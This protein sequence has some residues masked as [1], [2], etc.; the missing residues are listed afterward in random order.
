M[1]A[2]WQQEAPRQGTLWQR[3]VPIVSAAAAGVTVVATFAGC[4]TGKP[5]AGPAPGATLGSQATT[6]NTT[7]AT[8]GIAGSAAARVAAVQRKAQHAAEGEAGVLPVAPEAGRLSQ[9]QAFPSTHDA[10]FRDAMDDLWLAVTRDRPDDASRAFFPQA[11]YVQT[12]A[13]SYAGSD[14]LNRLWLDFELDVHAAHDLVGGDAHLVRVDMA[15]DGEAAWVPPGY[16]Y[17]AVGYWHINGARLVY[18]RYG[19]ERSIGIA[20]LISWRGVWYVVHFGGVVRPAVGIVDHP[21]PGPGYT[22]PAGG[23]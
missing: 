9:T 12:K 13:I 17:N 21:E 22:G 2:P 14:W 11:A 16:C 19:A 10:A 4:S 8:H 18:E 20:S 15:P 6:T 3:W 7:N 1:R 23:C 5:S